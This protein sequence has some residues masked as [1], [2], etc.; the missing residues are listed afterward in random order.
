[1][2]IIL[3]ITILN[4]TSYDCRRAGIGMGG[5]PG[6][7]NVLSSGSS[8]TIEGNTIGAISPNHNQEAGIFVVGS[9]SVTAV[10]GG[11]GGSNLIHYNEL[12]VM[13]AFS[14]PAYINEMALHVIHE[15]KIDAGKYISKVVSLENMVDEGIKAAEAGEALKVV[16]DPWL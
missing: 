15:G 7:S 4:N 5:P 1:M 3:D 9:G 12:I 14:Y 13:G 6:F 16:V 11:T 8:V 10:I 2:I